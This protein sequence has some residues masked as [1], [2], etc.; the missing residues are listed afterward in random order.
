MSFLDPIPEEFGPVC[1]SSN[2]SKSPGWSLGDHDCHQLLVHDLTQGT[3]GGA[4]PEVDPSGRPR[5]TQA[6]GTSARGVRAGSLVTRTTPPLVSTP[7][8]ST[9]RPCLSLTL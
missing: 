5:S 7:T 3:S 2:T 1:D 8:V 4:T 9:T 6:R